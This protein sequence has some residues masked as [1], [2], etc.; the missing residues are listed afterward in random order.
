[1]TEQKIV[2]QILQ[3][4]RPPPLFSFEYFPPKTEAGIAA[5]YKRVW[6]MQQ[7]NPLFMDLTWG[8]GGS[9]SE[10]TMTLAS[11]FVKHLGCQVNMHLTCTNIKKETVEQALLDAKKNG[12]KN[13]LALRGDPPAGQEKWAAVEG[14][15]ECALDLIKFIRKQHGDFFGISCAGYPEGHPNAITKVDDVDKLSASEK[16]RLVTTAEGEHW[17]CLDAD[18]EKEMVYLKEKVDAGAQFIVTQLFYDADTFL[19][20]EK[21]CRDIGINVPIFPGI[22]PIA[23]KGGFWRMTGLCK[24]R[25]PEDVKALLQATTTDEEFKQQG[26]NIV[27]QL[28][29]TLWESG[30]IF[31]LHYYTLNQDK[32]TFGLMEAMGIKLVEVDEKEKEIMYKKITEELCPKPAE[33]GNGEPAEKKAK[34]SA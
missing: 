11:N 9:T 27:H 24:T 33:N 6:R 26:H 7:Q 19:A 22:M 28:C 3:E 21:N 31:G 5:L 30:K 4:R 34:V 17:V 14:G 8:A 32:A 25:V 15:F 20:F 12:I 13:I 16:G 10:L 23:N 18:F 1:M 2:S 29:K